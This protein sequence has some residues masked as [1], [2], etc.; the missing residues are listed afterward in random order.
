LSCRK[1]DYTQEPNWNTPIAELPTESK[2]FHCRVYA[3]L[4]IVNPT[5]VHKDRESA[6]I[7]L[8]MRKK[9]VDELACTS[10]GNAAI[11]IS[12]FA[13]M[14]QFRPHIFVGEISEDKLQLIRVFEPEIH[15][16]RGAYLEAL[17][18]MLEYIKKTKIYNASAGYCQAKLEGNSYIGQEIA[19]DLNPDY[20]ICPTN[21]GTHFVGVGMG[22]RRAG[23]RAKMIAATAP[24]SAVASSITGFYAVE[25]PKIDQTIKMTDGQLCQ[26]DDDELLKSTRSLA[27]QGIFVE[28]ASA[29]SVAALP[30]VNPDKNSV[31]CCTVTGSAFKYPLA[32]QNSLRTHI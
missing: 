7:M 17:D 6:M 15:K 22:I 1:L 27:K 13:Y 14:N 28:P 24:H 21:N 3:K 11:S 32:L 31:V 18:A 4:E 23:C 12:A 25:Q 5:G 8:D 16:V 19:N 10:T 2:R 29:A 20:V 9:S 26:I 30:Q